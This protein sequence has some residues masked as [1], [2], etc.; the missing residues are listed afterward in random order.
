MNDWPC[1]EKATEMADVALFKIKNRLIRPKTQNQL[2][3]YKQNIQLLL[4]NRIDIDDG[5]CKSPGEIEYRL[6]PPR[7]KC[8]LR[9]EFFN[10]RGFNDVDYPF[11]DFWRLA[12]VLQTDANI[13]V[14][15]VLAHW[16]FNHLYVL[17]WRD[18]SN[19]FKDPHTYIA[20]YPQTKCVFDAGVRVVWPGNEIAFRFAYNQLEDREEIIPLLIA[21]ARTSKS[22]SARRFA[23]Y[24]FA[25]EIDRS[26]K[27]TYLFDLRGY[28]GAYIELIAET[29]YDNHL[30][31][32][33]SNPLFR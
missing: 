24:Y 5:L 14:C 27:S 22:Y 20:K 11:S 10:P 6:N 12:Q 26:V 8:H 7:Q 30:Q 9:I 17:Y 16:I 1:P 19:H 33:D 18:S 23:E 3:Q 29:Q 4:R 31:V 25:K 28:E 21:S 13:D 32:L 2:R 15:E